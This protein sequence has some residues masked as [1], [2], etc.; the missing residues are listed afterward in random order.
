MGVVLL[1][2]LW[3]ATFQGQSDPNVLVT[4]TVTDAETGEPIAGARVADNRYNTGPDRAPQEAWTDTNG[5]YSLSTWYEDHSVAA[6]APGYTTKLAIVP[7]KAFGH[8]PEVHL[9]FELER[10]PPFAGKMKKYA[11]RRPLLFLSL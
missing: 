11:G 5:L 6:S 2:K 8:E 1:A 9:D 7:T 10:Q 3:Q 4:G